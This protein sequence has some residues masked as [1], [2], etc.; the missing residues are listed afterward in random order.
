MGRIEPFGKSPL[1]PLLQRGEF[2][3]TK[4]IAGYLPNKIC[5]ALWISP[6]EKG[7]Q[8]E[9]FEFLIASKLRPGEGYYK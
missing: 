9:G 7:D 2:P 8:R 5:V 1:A 6:F 4:V 3:L